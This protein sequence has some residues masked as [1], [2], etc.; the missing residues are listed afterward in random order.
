VK[1]I[2]SDPILDAQWPYRGP[3]AFCGHRD[4]RHRE[5]DSILGH[6]RAEKNIRHGITTVAKHWEVAP[7][8]V[9]RLVELAPYQRGRKRRT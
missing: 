2:V 7:R 8:A 5:W 3:C 6:V 1:G 4:A 9:R